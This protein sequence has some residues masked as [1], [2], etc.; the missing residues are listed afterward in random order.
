M[1]GIAQKYP[2]KSNFL[3]ILIELIDTDCR[4]RLPTKKIE[5]NLKKYL[6]YLSSI[7]CLKKD[8]HINFNLKKYNFIQKLI[9]N[10]I[11]STRVT[12]TR[13]LKN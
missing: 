7:I 13:S 11:Y 6:L 5:E 8:K 9:G 10:L 12:I 3:F 4:D 2:G 1:H